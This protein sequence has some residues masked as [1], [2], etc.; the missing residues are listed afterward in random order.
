MSDDS[1]D[2]AVVTLL[3]EIAADP[4]AS[5]LR[6]P[7]ER[8]IRWVGRPEEVI[9]PSGSYLTKAE[10][11]LVKAYREEAAWV[12]LQACVVELKKQPLVFSTLAPDPMR[13]KQAA[14]SLSAAKSLPP[15]ARRA[16]RDL[17]S[18]LAL[19]AV[20]L[21]ATALRLVPTDHARNC[22]A[23]AFQREGRDV[24]S[25][26]ILHQ[27]LAGE[28]C[29]VQRAQAF[30][31]MAQVWSRRAAFH[32]VLASNKKAVAA[33]ESRV[34]LLVWCLTSALQAGDLRQAREFTTRIQEHPCRDEVIAIAQVL[35]AERSRKDW[36]PTEVSQRLVA[37]LVGQVPEIPWRVCHAFS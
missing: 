32:R 23:I 26:R 1:F 17:A 36:A 13:L 24:G 35:K 7:K 21:G 34:R 15:V 8:L 9:K 16:T 5:L 10:K 29:A 6:I 27:L 19:D 37:H 31:N 18:G 22:L 11:H 12:L 3:R 25:M 28:P 30:E 20:Q 2:P 4:R 33:D 14:E